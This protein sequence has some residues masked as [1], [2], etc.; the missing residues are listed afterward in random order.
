MGQRLRRISRILFLTLGVPALTVL[1][2]VLLINALVLVRTKPYILTPEEAA[3]L[4]DVDCILVLGCGVR[5][6]GRPS[7]M[8]ADRISEGVALYE[9]GVS[10]RLL[11]SGD[12]GSEYY[13]EVNTMKRIAGEAGIEADAI[14]CDHA[15]FS[16]YESMYRARDVFQV[17]RTVIVTQRYHLPRAIY[18]ARRLG[19]DAYGVSADLRSYAGQSFRDLRE[20]AARVKDFIFCIITPA[21]TF[22]GEP[23]PI[24]GKGS[25]TDG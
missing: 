5:P 11:M 12:H 9:A 3:E 7:D 25:L 2:F 15:G 4:G 10:Q 1:L 20:A 18:T 23:I 14:F 19:I 16:T 6:D 17:G 13:D 8:L 21:P 24:S 22:L